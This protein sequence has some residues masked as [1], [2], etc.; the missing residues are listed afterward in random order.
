[1]RI[2]YKF[3][4]G[5]NK[6]IKCSTLIYAHIIILYAFVALGYPS[7]DKNTGKQP[8]KYLLNIYKDFEKNPRILI[9]GSSILLIDYGKRNSPVKI[10]DSSD[11][12]LAQLGSTNIS[13]ELVSNQDTE[14]IKPISQPSNVDTTPPAAVADASTNN[15]LRDSSDNDVNCNNWEIDLSDHDTDS[16]V[17]RNDRL[18][19]YKEINLHDHNNYKVLDLSDHDTD[20]LVDINDSLDNLFES[21]DST[22]IPNGSATNQD[23]EPI[24]IQQQELLRQKRQVTEESELILPPPKAPR[25]GVATEKE[26]PRADV[27]NNPIQ[28]QQ[29]LQHQIVEEPLLEEEQARLPLSAPVAVDVEE[30]LILEEVPRADVVIASPI[31]VVEV[32]GE[33][34]AIVPTS[35][36]VAGEE[37]QEKERKKIVKEEVSAPPP[38]A[39]AEVITLIPIIIPTNT[40]DIALLQKQKEII[41]NIALA[42]NEIVILS[43]EFANS[44]IDLRLTNLRHLSNLTIL[45]GGDEDNIVPKNLWIS[46]IMG[47]AKYNGENMLNRYSGRTSA[48]AIGGDIELPSGNIIGGAYNYVLSNFK[49]NNRIDKVV[50]HTHVISI[51]GQTNL[52]DKLILQGF[53]SLASGNISVKLPSQNHLARTKFANTSYSSKVIIARKSRFGTILITP[54]IGFKCGWYNIAGYNENFEKQNISVATT[55]NQKAS[56]IMG[57]EAIIPMKINDTTKL[58]PGIHMEAERLLHNKQKNLHIQILLA[59]SNNREEVLLLEKPAKYNYKIGGIIII[60]RGAIE[61]MAVYDYLASNNKYSSHQGSLKLKLSF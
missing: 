19:I 27:V 52:S 56:G 48:T 30:A 31:K 20:S 23:T 35:R 17:D 47:I 4:T 57:I 58:I 54:Y 37:L 38:V 50:A 34:A 22:N 11:N 14:P 60:K 10:N 49:Y 18:H 41:K 3:S 2:L 44:T 9:P 5:K 16:L 40:E 26:E 6:I 36:E 7:P 59:I 53:F 13:S 1:M 8:L 51:Y 61:I 15:L 12:L 45:A 39:A 43:Y 55:N 29:E 21:L 28:E 33:T 25:S 42:M 46:G 32:S 24:H